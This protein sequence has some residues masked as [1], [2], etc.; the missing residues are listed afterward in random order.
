MWGVDSI[1][2]F[3]TA[4]SGYRHILVAVD[5]FTKWIEVRPVANVMSEEE[6]KFIQE[7]HTSLHCAQ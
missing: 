3:R 7:I 1:G 5:K 6:A 4:L 2:S